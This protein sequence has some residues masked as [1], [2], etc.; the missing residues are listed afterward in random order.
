CGRRADRKARSFHNVT[1]RGKGAGCFGHHFAPGLCFISPH[2]P[3]SWKPGQRRHA[4]AFPRRERPRFGE[5]RPA[6]D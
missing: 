2:V 4:T 3:A 1:A 5:K 6:L